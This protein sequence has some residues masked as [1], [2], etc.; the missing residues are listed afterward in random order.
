MVFDAFVQFPCKIKIKMLFASGRSLQYWAAHPKL[1]GAGATLG[2]GVT[3]AAS[4]AQSAAIVAAAK[5]NEVD[6]QYQ[7][8][9]TV[10]ARAQE[11]G[12]TH[13]NPKY[14]QLMKHIAT[15]STNYR[16]VILSPSHHQYITQSSPVIAKISPKQTGRT[17]R[18]RRRTDGPKD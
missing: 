8:S 11:K 12:P 18:V 5:A 9:G 4:K 15:I 1:T 14:R 16:H 10:K 2:D 13:R 17:H 3:F 7:L 6:S